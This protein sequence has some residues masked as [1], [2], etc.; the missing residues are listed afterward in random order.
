MKHA[1][2]T[3]IWLGLAG[4]APQP[5]IA[6]EAGDA[7]F[8]ER[9]PWDLDRSLEW[10]LTVQGPQ[11]EGF[12]PTANASLILSEETDPSDQQPI[13]Q[14]TQ[15]SGERSRKIGP[16]PISGGDPVLTFFLEQT[17]RDVAALTGGSAH[18]IRNRMKDALFRGGE[19]AQGDDGLTA[20]FQPFAEDPNA[21]RMGGFQTLRLT[22]VMA[23][24][25][26]PIRELRA[27][28][29]PEPGYTNS[30]VLQ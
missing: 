26:Q 14:L 22:F 29:D 5:L 2:A 20:T 1:I 30:L 15:D 7:V 24:P 3:A 4:L 8:A 16:F 25:A 21:D 27:E 23:D 10:R 6:A 9:G 19:I 12:R 17:S 11:A 13:L 18:Y 28:T